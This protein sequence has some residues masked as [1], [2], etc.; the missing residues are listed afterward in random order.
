MEFIA[1][2]RRRHFVDK[3][4]I[5][6]IAR[7]LKKS[8]PTIRKALQAKEEPVYRRSSQ[9]M[10]KLGAFQAQLEQWLEIETQLPKRQRRT[11]QRLYEGLQTEGYQGSYDSVQRFVRRWKGQRFSRPAVTQ[12][13]VPLSFPAGETG[14]FDSGNCSCVALP[15]ASMQSGATK[16]WNW[17]GWYKPSRWPTSAWLTAGR[18][19]WWPTRGKARRW[20]LMRTSEPSSS[21]GA[22]RSG[23]SRQLLLRCSTSCIHA[24]V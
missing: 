6:S 8:R 4:S 21:L 3:E 2:I 11:A 16:R 7:G 17:V 14:Q 12:A 10:P 23:W 1:E 18:C 15:P 13:F 22:C 5:S 9:P 19:S 24:V 20:Y